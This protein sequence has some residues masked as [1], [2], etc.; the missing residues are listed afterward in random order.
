MEE[1]NEL[2]TVDEFAEGYKKKYPQLRDRDNYDLTKMLI[3]KRPELKELVDFNNDLLSIDE[4]AK[5][6]KEKYP[7]FQDEDNYSL[8]ERLINKYPQFQDKVDFQKK[9]PNDP[10][11]SISE[12]AS[13]DITEEIGTGEESSEVIEESQGNSITNSYLRGS[14]LGI[15]NTPQKV[16]EEDAKLPYEQAAAKRSRTGDT[17]YPRYSAKDLGT[18]FADAFYNAATNQIPAQLKT[19]WELNP[20]TLA[21][22]DYTTAINKAEAEGLDYAEI[23]ETKISSGLGGAPAQP[24]TRKTVKV[25]L[26]EAKKRLEF[27]RKGAMEDLVDITLDRAKASKFVNPNSKL[28]DGINPKEFMALVGGQLPVLGASMIPVLGSGSMIY[29]DIYMENLTAIAAQKNK[30]EEQDV[31]PSMMMDVISKG[32]DEKAIALTGAAIATSLDVVG[33]GKAFN[34]IKGPATGLIREAVKKGIAKGGRAGAIKAVKRAGN[35]L[36]SG[37][38]E[39]GTEALQGVTAQVSK[40]LALGRTAIEAFQNIDFESANEEGLAGAVMGGGMAIAHTPTFSSKEVDAMIDENDL[41]ALKEYTEGGLINWKAIPDKTKSKLEFEEQTIGDKKYTYPSG[42]LGKNTP[43]VE[44]DVKEDVDIDEQTTTDPTGVPSMDEGAEPNVDQADGQARPGTEESTDQQGERI[45]EAI[46]KPNVYSRDGKKGAI[47]TDGQTVVL[48]TRDQVIELGNIDEIADKEIS[49]LGLEK[50]STESISVDDD[51]SVTIDEDKYNNRFSD[52]SQSINYNEDGEVVSV[53]LETEKGQKRTIRGQRAEEI[54]YQ[55]KQKEFENEATDE[56]IERAD[57]EAREIAESESQPT[58]TNTEAEVENTSEPIVEEVEK[59]PLTNDDLLEGE[60]IIDS[61]KDEKGR[62][63]TYTS[64]KSEKDGVKTTKFSFNRDD[65]APDSRN[66]SGVSPELAFNNEFEVSEKDQLDGM[67]VSQVFE[68]REGE[69][70]IGATVRFTD[71]VG[72]SID[73]EVVLE[74]IKPITE[75]IVEPNVEQVDAEAG[76]SAEES[77]NQQGKVT[78]Q[79]GKSFT[80]T[81]NKRTDPA[82]DMGSEFGQDVEV[83][84]DY[85]TQSEGFTPEGSET[86]TVTANSPLVIDV[87][88]DTQISYKNDLSKKYQGRKGEKLK[89]AIIKDGYDAVV[90]RFEDGTT[91]EIV[92]LDNQRQESTSTTQQKESNDTIL[93]PETAVNEKSKGKIYDFLDKKDKE[94]SKFGKENLSFGLPIAVAQGAIKTMKLAIDTARTGAD[95]IKAGVDYVKNTDWYKNQTKDKKAEIDTVLSN[96]DDFINFASEVPTKPTK[97]EARIERLKDTSRRLRKQFKDLKEYKKKLID[98]IYKKLKLKTLDNLS[99]YFNEPIFKQIN[100]APTAGAVDRLISKIDY[101]IANEQLKRIDQ[102]IGKFFKD[103]KKFVKKVDGKPKG[104]IV[105][106]KTRKVLVDKI[107]ARLSQDLASLEKDYQDIE[108]NLSGLSEEDFDKKLIELTAIESAIN[109]KKAQAL[110]DDSKALRKEKSD[111]PKDFT[112]KE[113]DDYSENVDLLAEGIR[114]KE[115]ALNDLITLR[116]EG[117]SKLKDLI[118]KENLRLVDIQNKGIADTENENSDKLSSDLKNE[119]DA[120]GTFEKA[121]RKALSEINNFTGRIAT[122]SFEFLSKIISNNSDIDLGFVRQYF[123]VLKTG[124]REARMNYVAERK[125]DDKKINE[126]IAKTFKFKNNAVRFTLWFGEATDSNNKK[127]G[128]FTKDKNGNLVEQKLSKLKALSIYQWSKMPS[129]ASNLEAAGFNEE[130]LKQVEEFLGKDFMALGDF[131]TSVLEEKFPEY[132]EKYLELMRTE[133]NQVDNYFPVQYI[134]EDLNNKTDVSQDNVNLLPSITPSHTIS[135]VKNDKALDVSVDALALFN[136]YLEKMTQF[137]HYSRATK[138]IN[139]LLS[140]SKFKKNLTYKE[141]SGLLYEQLV[142]AIKFTIGGNDY[143]NNLVDRA[144]RNAYKLQR[145]IQ[146]TYVGFKLW[147]AAKQLLSFMAAY[148]YA[149]SVYLNLNGKRRYIPFAGTAKFTSNLLLTLPRMFASH[150]FFMKNSRGY[151][152]RVDSGDVGSEQIKQ[153]LEGGKPS[154][155]RLAQKQAAKI[156]L[157]FNKAVDLLTIAWTG[158]VIYDQEYKKFRLKHSEAVAREKA[159]NQFEIYF[160]LSQ[161]ASDPEV[162]GEAQRETSWGG[163]LTAFKNSQIAYFR[164]ISG[165]VRSLINSHRNEKNRLKKAGVKDVGVKAI[166]KLL[167]TDSDRKQLKKILLYGY[168]MPLAWQ[169]VASGLPGMLSEWDDEDESQMKRALLLGPIDG[170]FALTD[171]LK[172]GTSVIV[173]GK[174]WRYSPVILFEELDNLIKDVAKASDAG[175]IGKTILAVK[176]TLRFGG[177]MDLDVSIRMYEAIEDIIDEKGIASYENVMKLMNAPKSITGESSSSGGP[178]RLMY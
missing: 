146:L 60:S 163:L 52:P 128:I 111:N 125:I 71:D 167:K 153:L 149:D 156:A 34:I 69:S 159:I 19:T 50:E 113:K 76:L 90:T 85:V 66:V 168:A 4:F 166:G 36:T 30:V 97:T 150:K 121:W 110:I 51:Y 178:G 115:Q 74:K 164:K 62:T 122:S 133:I 11:E 41:G 49:E 12:D 53:N 139:S 57:N 145:S 8:T 148:E 87:N 107:N 98:D 27:Y 109:L 162:L 25:P 18:T 77:T 56:Q 147:T 103:R 1:E 142:Q 126:F 108:N 102:A 141:E 92:L 91:S 155:R 176:Y 169:Y 101:K 31:T 173:D 21:V 96:E 143:S 116:D 86:G 140:N 95:I 61:K 94:L 28:S 46:D 47:T 171:L 65:K 22:E 129:M 106:N 105:D 120:R 132:N 135:R 170:L 44:V 5:G 79:T 14:T 161:Q 9:N 33:L 134:N 59:P 24:S 67:N 15:V 157:Y 123:Y 118:R 38:V 137:K 7:Q 40:Q 151:K 127:T 165:S 177:I 73:G 68:I 23:E 154:F 130:S 84:G 72:N 16:S 160:Q 144:G 13:M 117:K 32:E 124:F 17:G 48:E 45:S 26:D 81:Y 104:N 29:G 172:I 112:A 3:D 88:E 54:A 10:T 63:Y 114:L 6:F 70:S 89:D 37:A 93:K 83:A 78:P 152:D 131:M 100:N 174:R 58:E 136:N 20:K 80:F 158:K 119:K 2:L 64:K 43:K 55:Y 75:P 175:Y 39:Y 42:I 99:N 35:I 138:D 82:P